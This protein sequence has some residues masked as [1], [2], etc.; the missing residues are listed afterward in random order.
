MAT[1]QAEE[2]Q[3]CIS[4]E[5]FDVEALV[6]EATWKDILV[7][8]VRKNKIDPWD[9]DILEVVDR[10]VSAVRELKV[11]DLRV[12]ANIILAASM[13]LGFKSEVLLHEEEQESAA[14][15]QG[16]R[17]RQRVEVEPLTLRLRLP[18]KRRLT[19]AELVAALDEAMK[20]REVRELAKKNLQVRFPLMFKS[21]DIEA[22]TERVY[23][24]V[25]A[26]ADKGSITTFSTLSRSGGAEDIL[27]GLF[28]PLLFLAHR[29]KVS[30]VQERFFGEIIIALT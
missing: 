24:M 3:L 26:S 6:G 4:A 14:E 29:G 9:I 18:P 23:Q 13:L 25:K 28:I 21:T 8:L 22:E 17:P 2:V 12:P 27:I 20:L 7:D 1:V 19:L 11:M 10:Y 15:V 5:N 16:M 30:L